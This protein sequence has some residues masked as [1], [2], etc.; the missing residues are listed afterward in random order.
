ME[1]V[2]EAV[3]EL[4]ANKTEAVEKQFIDIGFYCLLEVLLCLRSVMRS[5]AI[6]RLMAGDLSNEMIKENQ[7]FLKASAPRNDRRSANKPLWQL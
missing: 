3:S 6:A 2:G 5:A 1:R 4:Q 7:R